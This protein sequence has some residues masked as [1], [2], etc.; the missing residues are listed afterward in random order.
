MLVL[1]KVN[2]CKLFF[3]ITF[4]VDKLITE[5]GLTPIEAY[6]KLKR[7]LEQINAGLGMLFVEE[8]RKK[9]VSTLTISLVKYSEFI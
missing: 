8:Y 1:N 7:V 2:I 3:F 5:L 6:N 9:L 4:Q